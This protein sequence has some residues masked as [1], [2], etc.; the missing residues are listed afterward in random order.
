MD[1]DPTAPFT[2]VPEL[3]NGAGVL[4]LHGFTGS[5]W[6]VRPLGDALWARGYRVHAPCLPGHGRVP[7]A[8]LHVSHRD[9]TQA[10]FAALDALP[11]GAP[12]FVAG[13]SMGALLAVLLAAARPDRVRAA[14]LMAPVW[15]LNPLGGRLLRASR[16]LPLPLLRRRWVT[17]KASDLEDAQASLENPLLPRYPVARL[18]DLFEL[19]DAARAAAPRV[20]QPALVVAAAHDHVVDMAGVR[21]LLA[22]LP[23]GRLVLLQ[24]GFHVLPRD[25]DRA[26]LCDE[27]AAFLDAPASLPAP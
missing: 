9:W 11:A 27:V 1:A 7:E 19:Q 4:L 14:V 15:R 12:T 3:P 21:E 26:L 22:A 5:P 8:M 16:R 10:A 2:L 6:E 25:K 17:K 24:Q 23:R 13:L 20:S 18:F